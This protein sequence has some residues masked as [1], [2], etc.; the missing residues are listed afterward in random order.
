MNQFRQRGESTGSDVNTSDNKSK[1]QIIKE[2][3]G[4][5]GTEL[6]ELTEQDLDGHPDVLSL[7]FYLQFPP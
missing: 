2:Q 4:S 3:E 5:I 1:V 6:Q 7:G